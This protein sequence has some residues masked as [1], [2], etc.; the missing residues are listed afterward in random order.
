MQYVIKWKQVFKGPRSIEIYKI[1]KDDEYVYYF[2]FIG[3]FNSKAYFSRVIETNVESFA[4]VAT[5]RDKRF[6]ESI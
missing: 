1:I 6:V 4:A 3:Q 5:V 2:Y